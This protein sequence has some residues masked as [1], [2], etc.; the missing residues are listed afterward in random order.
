VAGRS[1]IVPVPTQ[2]NSRDE[3]AELQAGRRRLAYHG[4]IGTSLGA[5][6]VF[7]RHQAAKPFFARDQGW[8]KLLKATK[9]SKLR[10]KPLPAHLNAGPAGDRMAVLR[11]DL[12]AGICGGYAPKRRLGPLG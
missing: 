10:A 9:F 4:A 7:D 1:S 2:R 8:A 11:D 3:N 12:P 6:E 5:A